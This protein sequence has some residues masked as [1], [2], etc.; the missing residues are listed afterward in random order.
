MHVAGPCGFGD[1]IASVI[2]PSTSSR[3]SNGGVP[4]LTAPIRVPSCQCLPVL[5]P[6]SMVT[7]RTMKS[8][9]LRRIGAVVAISP[10]YWVSEIS[11]R[12]V[13]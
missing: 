10:Q 7:S 5:P 12:G 3:P 9:R 11:L 2:S 8:C 13:P 1:R 6:G 4:C